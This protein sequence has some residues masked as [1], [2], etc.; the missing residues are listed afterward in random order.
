MNVI[1]SIAEL[2]AVLRS[3]GSGRVGLVPTMGA[4]HAG[5]ESLFRAARAECAT[6]VASVF[7]NPAQF[8][9]PADLERYPRD[10][11]HDRE[12]AEG[13]G[14]DLLFAPAVGGNLSAGLRHL[15][16]R[17]EA[18]FDSR[19]GL[20]P[21]ALSRRRN[22]LPEAV[23]HRAPGRGLLRPEG[24]AAGA[25]DP[26]DDP[27]PAPGRG[28]A[29]VSDRARRGW[30]RPVVAQRAPQCRRARARARAAACAGHAETRRRR[31]RC[32]A[33]SRSS[34]S[35]WRR[36]IRPCWQPPSVSATVRLIDNAP[37]TR[38]PS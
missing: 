34:T 23:Q 12:M 29:S 4:L 15:G 8:G 28:A 13:A 16:R 20:P 7:V 35:R 1:R 36:S 11:A 5:H 9:E 25:G 3:R 38:G 32:S 14:V 24:R 26:P 10:E 21:G 2:R 37:L 22:D 17:R 27:G 6:V 19:R 33:A 30:S 18:R 31:A